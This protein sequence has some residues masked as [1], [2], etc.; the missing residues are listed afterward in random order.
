MSI[1]L[2]VQIIDMV[3]LFSCFASGYMSKKIGQKRTMLL[4]VVSMTI[5]DALIVLFNYLES[6]TG[7]IIS[8]VLFIF[9][10]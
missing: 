5:L 4:G 7:I 6:S 2:A 10:Y 3:Y 9:S 8:L 1:T